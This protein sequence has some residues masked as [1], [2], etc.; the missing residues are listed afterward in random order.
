[1]ARYQIRTTEH[2]LLEDIVEL[3][4]D[5]SWQILKAWEVFQTDPT[6]Q[7]F[8]R[9]RK[10]IYLKLI[11]AV[12][13]YKL[14][15]LSNICLDATEGT[16]WAPPSHAMDASPRDFIYNLFPGNGLEDFLDGLTEA[17]LKSIT[18]FINPEMLEEVHSILKTAFRTI[19]GEYLYFNPLCGKTEL[20]VYS[21]SAP[22]KTWGR[23]R[24]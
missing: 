14:C 2:Q 4:S 18:N 1:M 23:E 9:F 19:L 7:D 3:M 13:S 16:P 24:N 20:C 17:A 21:M 8:N 11:P 12:K 15:G 10:S 22:Q 5:K 6:T